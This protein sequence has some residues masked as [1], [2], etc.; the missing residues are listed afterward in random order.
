MSKINIDNLENRDICNM[1]F[2]FS[3]ISSKEI[4]DEAI[5]SIMCEYQKSSTEDINKNKKEI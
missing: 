2:R 3:K 1:A 5:N 4:Y